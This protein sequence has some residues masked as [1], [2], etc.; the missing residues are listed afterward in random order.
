MHVDS[1]ICNFTED[2]AEI[3]AAFCL[4]LFRLPAVEKCKFTKY[5]NQYTLFCTYKNI[6]YR[7]TG[8]SRLGDIW[9]VKD[10]TRII[11][12]DLRVDIDD[13]SNFTKD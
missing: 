7:V 12:Y 9:L 6:K 4:M 11:G 8:A 13:C 5:T 2:E 10:H 3:Y 1:F